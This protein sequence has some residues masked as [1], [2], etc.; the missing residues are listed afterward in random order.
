MVFN[1]PICPITQE[2]IINPV[3]DRE[4]NTYEREAIKEKWDNIRDEIQEQIDKTDDEF[5]KEGLKVAKQGR[6]KKTN[7]RRG[8]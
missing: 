5:K 7:K 2:D 1:I 3:I 4:G 6:W 8:R